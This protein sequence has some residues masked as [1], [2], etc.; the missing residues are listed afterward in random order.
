MPNSSLWKALFL[1][2]LAFTALACITINVYFPEAVVKDLSEKI[3]EAVIR[4]AAEHADSPASEPT[5]SDNG[6]GGEAEGEKGEGGRVLAMGPE[7]GRALVERPSF[8]ELALTTL[9]RLTAAPIEAQDVAAPEISNPAIRKI[10]ESRARR[11]SE[12]DGQK[13]SGVLG[14]NNQALL[15]V[16]DLGSLPLQQRAAVQKLVRDENADRE[17]M[18]REIAAATNVDLSQ[19]PRIQE[20]YAETLRQNAKKG[21]WIQEPNGQWRQK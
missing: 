11:V 9:A 17:R 20:T 14:E 12:I 3:E 8:A 16:R 6:A 15:E 2:V 5:P 7:I 1:A 19:L 4:E 10:V 21:H 13:D 18:F